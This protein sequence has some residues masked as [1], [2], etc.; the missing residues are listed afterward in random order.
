[1]LAGGI[2]S[3]FLWSYHTLYPAQLWL[4]LFGL[5]SGLYIA[6]ACFIALVSGPMGIY[7]SQIVKGPKH[8]LLPKLKIRKLDHFKIDFQINVL[9]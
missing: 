1:L 7:Q 6:I 2:C 3:R 9:L 8:L 4:E 5:E